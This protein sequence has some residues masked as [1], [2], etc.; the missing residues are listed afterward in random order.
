MLLKLMFLVR[1]SL[2]V[3]AGVVQRSSLLDTKRKRELEYYDLEKSVEAGKGPNGKVSWPAKARMLLQI[4]LL[5]RSRTA[6]K[7]AK[8]HLDPVYTRAD[9]DP[10]GSVP[11]L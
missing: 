1:S 7:D 11:K 8:R 10:I 9:A 4:S 2:S 3:L 5:R 6:N